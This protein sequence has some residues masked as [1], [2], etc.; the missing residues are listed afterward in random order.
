MCVY[1]YNL[2]MSSL[3]SFRVNDTH[4]DW[5]QYLWDL[6]SFI[7]LLLIKNVV[8]TNFLLCLDPLK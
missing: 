3:F 4:K 7:F 5:L 8:T 1:I 6:N 2:C